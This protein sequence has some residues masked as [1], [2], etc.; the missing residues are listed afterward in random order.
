MLLVSAHPVQ[1][2]SP[3][4]R[5]MAQHPQ[6]QIQV[7]YCS[8][9]G[10]EA[11][12]D[13]EFGVEVKWDVPLLESY[14]WVHVPNRSPRPGLGRFLGLV[15][16]G[17]WKLIASG[18]FDAVV[19]YTGYAYASF[20]IALAAAKFRHVPILFGTD[21][22][23][24]A[25]LDGRKWKATVKRII[26]PRIFGLASVVIVPSTRSVAM[27]RSLGI[28]DRRLVM[29]PYVVDNDWWAA[30]SAKVDRYAVRRAWEVPAEAPVV[31][32]CAKLQPW[33]R[34]F[35]LM[36]AFVQADVRDS[37]L[38][39]A[40]EGPLR[41]ELETRARELGI[42]PRAHFLGFANQSQLPS[43][44]RA[45]DLLVLPSDYDAFG[46]VVNE[47]MVCGCSAIVSDRVGASGDLIEEGETGNVY[48]CGDVD[49]LAALLRET[50]SSP[51]RLRQ[52]GQAARLRIETWSPRENIQALVEAVTRSVL[53]KTA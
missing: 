36:N 17:L 45:A 13:P 48:P 30:Q 1:Y 25:P 34:P 7:A 24:L 9:Q 27:M 23:G 52:M 51:E 20:W 29:T 46:V 10:A 16:P 37:H 53:A 40:G 43:I 49:R 5:R 21:A 11:G 50:L 12:V 8:L 15:N 31:L 38:V 6:L 44:Y 22:H 26:W 42:G 3:M 41:A 19:V 33:K 35:D 47:A 32:F 4:Y 18:G 39:F 14:P 28:P 2:A